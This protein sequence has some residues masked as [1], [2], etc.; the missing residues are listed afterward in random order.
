MEKFTMRTLPVK[1]TEEE[2]AARAQEHAEAEFKRADAS[3]ALE[4]AAEDWKEDKKRLENAETAAIAECWRLARVVKYREEPRE[5]KCQIS[6][7]NGQYSIAR[8]DTGEVVAQRPA[9]N[10]ELQMTLEEAAGSAVD[11]AVSDAIAAAGEEP[12]APTLD[13]E[14]QDPPTEDGPVP[15][16]EQ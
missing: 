12:D 14:P 2:L 11:G 13:A 8:T 3:T 15:Q 16:S 9:S 1:L 7:A 5:V 6:V 4:S 10:D